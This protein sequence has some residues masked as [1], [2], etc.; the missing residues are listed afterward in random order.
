MFSP[1]FQPYRESVNVSRMKS[2]ARREDTAGLASILIRRVLSG[3]I[4][5]L[6]N[7]DGYGLK[8]PFMSQFRVLILAAGKGKRM[9]SEIPKTLIPIGGKPVL[10][11]LVEAV[12]ASGVD[13]KPIVVIGPEREPICE[14]FGGICEYVVQEEPLGTGHA[15]MTCEQ[16]ARGA[17]HVIVLYG[18]HPFVSKET[19]DRLTRRHTSN[20]NVMTMMTTTVPHLDD[21]YKVFGHWGRILRDV[22][23]CIMG[24]RQFKDAM[25]SEREVRELDPALYCFRADWLWKNIR[26]LRNF[27]AQQEYYLTDMVE[28]AVTQGHEIAFLDIAPEEAVGMN[29]PEERDIAEMIYQKYHAGS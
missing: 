15:V 8:E 3:M 21:W 16:A 23:G 17:E 27:N 5:P 2:P 24:I 10:Q 4:G 19:L 25:D 14:T 22:H 7:S 1:L 26:Q 11:H 18:D 13:E 28:L 6:I 29:T 20:G 12:L 9:G